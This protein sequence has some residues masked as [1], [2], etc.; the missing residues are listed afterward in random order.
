MGAHRSVPSFEG[1]ATKS[2]RHRPVYSS[3]ILCGFGRCRTP[4]CWD[5]HQP[6]HLNPTNY[7][8]GEFGAAHAKSGLTPLPATHTEPLLAAPRSTVPASP[9]ETPQ[10][11]LAP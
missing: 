5:G 11:P 2:E 1:R 7:L 6:D 8:S 10:T 4:H 9:A 3:F